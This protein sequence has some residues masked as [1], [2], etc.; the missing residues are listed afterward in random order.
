MGKIDFEP[1]PKSAARAVLYRDLRNSSIP[2]DGTPAAIYE[3]RKEFDQSDRSRWANRLRTA[4]SKVKGEQWG[5]EK[6]P[7]SHK[8]S[9]AYRALYKGFKTGS[10]QMDTTASDAYA[11]DASFSETRPDLWADRFSS[12]RDRVKAKKEAADSDYAAYLSD[13]KLHPKY[14]IGSDGKTR[15]EGSAAERLL[16]K[17]IDDDNHIVGFLSPKEL[18]ESRDEY[19]FEFDLGVFRG[20]IH[21]L[22]KRRKFMNQ[23]VN[24]GDT[25]SADKEPEGV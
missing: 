22:I 23:Y 3:M 13:R 16:E 20:H 12:M 11:M 9:P 4:K 19:Y 25:A 7:W 17:D 21:Q 5:H 2:L 1:W 18:W 6:H 14:E 10:I 24:G 15:W 8:K